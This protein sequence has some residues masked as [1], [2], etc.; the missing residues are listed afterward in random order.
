M[1]VVDSKG[2]AT[3]GAQAV[4][5]GKLAC[6]GAAYNAGVA[7]AVDGSAY[8]GGPNSNGEVGADV[9]T[10]ISEEYGAPAP[11]CFAGPMLL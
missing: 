4:P 11:L 9:K 3:I 8:G 1:A 2:H 5:G 6:I 10:A 7:V